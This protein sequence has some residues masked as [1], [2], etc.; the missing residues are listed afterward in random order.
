[1][2]RRPRRAQ[3]VVVT[4][5][6]VTDPTTPPQVRPLRRVQRP[7]M[8]G[9]VAGGLAR[10]LDRSPVVLRVAFA[11]LA[12]LYG[13]GV[14]LYLLAWITIPLE[15]RDESAAD[16]LLR[17]VAGAPAW[18]RIVLLAGAGILVL[19]GLVGPDLGVLSGVVLIAAGVALFRRDGQAPAPVGTPT[20]PV[21]VAQGSGAT[22]LGQP[23]PPPRS[24]PAASAPTPRPPRPRRE[25]S[26]LGRL[27]LGATLLVLG[28]VAVLDLLGAIEVSAE[29][30]LAL[31]LAMIGAGLLVGARFGR[32]RGLILLAVPLL[33]A[34]VLLNLVGPSRTGAMGGLYERPAALADVRDEY[35]VAAGSVVLD[36]SEVEFGNRPTRVAA[37]VG[38]GDLTVFVPQDATVEVTGSVR[39]GL[40]DL[41]DNTSQGSELERTVVDQGRAGGGRLV[42]DLEG[43]LAEVGVRRLEGE[44]DYATP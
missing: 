19:Q 16:A 13:L 14:V 5:T 28:L 31:S 12:L 6:T 15:G 35:R 20:A 7:R 42:L 41:F 21:P 38:L 26:V 2:V 36:L 34:L 4:E 37:S 25:P 3:D 32:A 43:G 1:M 22:A 33:G 10:Y 24:A 23:P 17:R 30:L 40:L 27:T 11:L 44:S 39:A 8:L 9:G 18:L 29:T